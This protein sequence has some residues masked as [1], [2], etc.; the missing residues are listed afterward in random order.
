MDKEKLLRLYCFELSLHHTNASLKIWQEIYNFFVNSFILT[1]LEMLIVRFNNVLHIQ[2][3]AQTLLFMKGIAYFPPQV[4]GRNLLS[5]D[6][7]RALRTEKI[8]DDHRKFLLKIIYD[9]Q[10]HPTL[11]VPSCSQVPKLLSVNL[12]YSRLEHLC[13]DIFIYAILQTASLK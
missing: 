10:G 4:N 3:S 2:I 12:T 9:N 7:D 13:W 11:W 8:Y 1:H 5:V 6:Y